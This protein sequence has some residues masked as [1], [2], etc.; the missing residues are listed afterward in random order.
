MARPHIADGGDG[1]KIC[2]PLSIHGI[3][4]NLRRTGGVIRTWGLVEVTK[5]S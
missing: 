3:R 5:T 2:I 1:L 4:D